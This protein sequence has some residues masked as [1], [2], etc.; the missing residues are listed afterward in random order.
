MTDQLKQ[1]HAF[2]L[3]REENRE[4]QALFPTRLP[5]YLSLGIPVILSKAGDLPLYLEH[6]KSA[7]LIPPGHAA[8][9]LAQA[10]HHLATHEDDRR[11]IGRGGWEVASSTLSCEKLGGELLAF[12]RSVVRRPAE[13]PGRDAANPI[14]ASPPAGG[15]HS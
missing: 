12:L 8:E 11:A 3:L 4:T 10:I 1:A 7:W 9:D 2:V 13:E 15:L 14:P 5:E 6:R